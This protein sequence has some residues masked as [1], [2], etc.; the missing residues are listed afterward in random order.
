MLGRL[1][2]L[3][4]AMTLIEVY[5]LMSIGSLLGAELTIG[6]II[7]TAFAGSY[8]VR[9]QGVQTVQKLQ[10][11]LAAGEAPGQE[12]V[13]GIMLLVCGVLL[14]T[15]GFV[16]DALGLLVLTPQ[17]RGRLAKAIIAQ[18]KDRIIPQS[19]FTGGAQGF[20]YSSQSSTHTSQSSP[21]QQQPGADSKAKNDGA[22]EGD[23]VEVN[24]DDNKLN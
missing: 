6:I 10:A 8:L 16:T 9:S 20:S 18:Y 21:F 7:L 4:T 13:E 1:F 5:V 15:P 17:I 14:V 22:I 11:R 3:F 12:I 23:F 2:F 24:R 19:T